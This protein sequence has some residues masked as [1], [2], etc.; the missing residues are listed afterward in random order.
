MYS[1]SFWKSWPL[2]YQRLL[3][4]V[5]I[6]LLVSLLFLWFAYFRSPAPALT[7]RT[8][9]EQAAVEVPAHSFSVGVFD[10][11]VLAHSYVLFE[12]FLGNPLATQPV[13]AC[14]FLI[15]LVFCGTIMLAIITTLSRFW[16][17]L[18]M[19]LFIAFV[20]GFR[21]ELIQ[22][23][24]FINKLPT[25]IILIIY[26]VV[27][28][29]FHAFNTSASFVKRLLTFL[30]I[31][32]VVCATLITSAK[33][34]HAAHQLA[35]TGY[36]AGIIATVLFIIMVSHEILASFIT[37]LTHGTRQT[38][39]LN[40]FLIISAIYMV[41]LFIAYANKNHW[42]EWDFMVVNLFLLLTLSG[43]L[44]I[45]GFRQRAP[46]YQG[47]L[48]ADPFGVYFF[49][50]LA[51]IAFSMIGWLITTANDPALE[52]IRDAILYCHLGYGLIF[53]LYVISN[54]ISML[55]VNAQVYKVLY[56]PNRMPYFTF[57]FAGLIATLA[58]VFYNTW[59]VPVHNAQSGYYNAQGDVFKS[60]HPQLAAIYYDKASLY[61]FL[62][63]HSNYATADIAALLGDTD[64]EKSFYKR[65][66][67][68]R[69]TEMSFLNWSQQLQREQNW[70][71]AKEILRE[72]LA[73]FPNSGAI[74]NTLGLAYANLGATDS[75]LYFFKKSAQEPMTQITAGN[76]SIGVAAVYHLPL[77]ADSLYKSSPANLVAQ[78]NA[79]TLASR[80][81][82]SLEAATPD[83][84]DTLLNIHRATFLNNYLINHVSADSAF[85]T[86]VVHLIQKPANADYR[87]SLTFA[88][89]L[90]YYRQGQVRKAFQ[91]LEGILFYSQTPG[92]YNHV[93]AQWCL[94]QS[95]PDKA[96]EFLDYALSQHYERAALTNAVALAEASRNN[97]AL[98]AWDTL[99]L[100]GDSAQLKLSES[101]KRVLAA[102]VNLVQQLTDAEKYQY[103]RYKIGLQDFTG[104][105]R[106][107]ATIQQD[108]DKARAILDRS[109]KL[110]EQD[111][112]E[113]ALA[114]FTNIKGLRL[115]N[116]S[117]FD[118]IQ[119]FD[120]KLI[121]A[122]GDAVTL[123]KQFPQLEFTWRHRNE[124]IYFETLLAAES[125]DF[126]LTNR[127]FSYLATANPF[128]EEAV[129]VAAEFF[130][131]NS[132]QDLKAYNILTDALHAN[133][134]SVKLLKAYS[135]EAVRSGLPEFAS[136][137]IN[138]LQGQISPGAFSKFV[139]ENRDL[140]GA[141]VN[142]KR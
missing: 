90:S 5:A 111:E 61:G 87:E 18:G 101:V 142:T 32:T 48:E 81:E 80:D 138:Q 37:L 82:N 115:R 33:A 95:A 84:T 106:V 10:L 99:K 66:S 100:A 110:Y 71:Q 2:V 44:G 36:V 91:L 116:K 56:K 135:L 4:L 102:P 55:G 23:F 24:G 73:A 96:L 127:N 52:T 11:T 41:N 85:V 132:I 43:I 7:W 30:F 134:Q 78:S 64:K 21:L 17:A 124:R 93:L 83:M 57:S 86:Q 22:A 40:H 133:P 15:T 126:A 60:D 42:I 8:V 70:Y 75:A 38:K 98:V 107:L 19:G 62:N 6:S 29:Y 125:G 105:S 77:N 28:F 49:V 92:E 20:I 68:N 130:R 104:F 59:Q 128:F 47:I 34:P 50:C 1:V 69:P 120:L 63:H 109:R 45:W 13:A 123:R 136:H 25:I 113:Q 46:Q 139:S 58:F 119:M 65:A 112:L 88:C 118:E 53:I 9:Q 94:E 51:S 108:D 67:G 3:A 72:G 140:L 16:Y 26:L 14:I 79:L 114:V 141:L 31:T 27:S 54:F 137:S 39:S 74:G 97:E 89:A 117:L 121:A 35:A 103:T 122:R 131:E 76:N 129:V 12:R